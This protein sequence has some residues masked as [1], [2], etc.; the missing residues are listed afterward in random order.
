MLKV[1]V[2]IVQV[3]CLFLEHPVY[4]FSQ[5]RGF[6]GGL[7][8]PLLLNLFFWALERFIFFSFLRLCNIHLGWLLGHAL[9]CLLHLGV[10]H[11]LHFWVGHVHLHHVLHHL[12]VVAHIFGRLLS[13]LDF[14]LLVHYRSSFQRIIV[15]GY[16]GSYFYVVFLLAHGCKII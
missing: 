2:E 9:H 8:L 10:H 14:R 1:V 13:V 16:F 4:S 12:H 11:F 3:L 7:L 5:I 6:I 15:I